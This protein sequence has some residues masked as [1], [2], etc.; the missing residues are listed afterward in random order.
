MCLTK[1]HFDEQ[2]KQAIVSQYFTTNYASILEKIES[3]D[4]IAYGK[5]RNY[6]DGDITYLSPYISRGVISTKQMVESVLARGYRV[7]QIESFIKECCWRDYFQRV[8]QVKNVSQDIK[9]EQVPVLNKAIPQSIVSANTGNEGIDNAIKELYETGYMHNHCRMYTASVV[10]NIAQSH[11]YVPAQ[12]MYYHLLDGDWASNACSWQWVAGAN[13]SKKYY[14]NQENINRYTKTNQAN[15][16]LDKSYEELATMPVPQTLTETILPQLQTELPQPTAALQL[17]DQLPTFV[18]NY[19]NLSPSW[20]ADEVGNKVLLLEPSFFAEYPV[21]KQCIE[22]IL[23]LSKNIAGIQ[24][25]VGSFAELAQQVNTSA[26]YFKE[27]PLNK[28]YTGIEEPRDW[29]AEKITGYSPSFFSY[30]KKVEP[31]VYILSR[32]HGQ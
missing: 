17:N 7:E 18:Y 1:N 6:I 30:W 2:N 28:G 9:Q 5:T 11:W 13:S 29:L 15:T 3:I 26:I 25:F 14:A 8:A 22:F 21:S 23:D 20:H 24:L 32:K 19:Y 10:C 16:F 27:H 4:P 12:W 31:H